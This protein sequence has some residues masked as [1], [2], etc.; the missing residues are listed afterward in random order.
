[1]NLVYNL[2]KG[3]IE[4][5]PNDRKTDSLQAYFDCISEEKRS[6]IKAL[7]M[8]MWGPYIKATADT[9]G[10]DKIVIDLFHVMKHKVVVSL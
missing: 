7:A 1:L 9:I 10:S 4:H 6:F 8:D 3:T 2:E 5:I